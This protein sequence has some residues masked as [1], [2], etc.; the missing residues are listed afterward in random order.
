[1]K[2]V[3][4]GEDHMRTVARLIC[5]VIQLFDAFAVICDLNHNSR[6]CFVVVMIVVDTVV[7]F[8]LLSSGLGS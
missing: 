7:L 6:D 5:A 4:I 3:F 2:S 8:L 1:M